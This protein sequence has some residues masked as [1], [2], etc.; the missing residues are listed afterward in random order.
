MSFVSAVA[1]YNCIIIATDG[2]AKKNGQIVDEDAVKV[3]V[4][5]PDLVIAYTGMKEV[6]EEVITINKEFIN[7][8]K[9]ITAIGNTLYKKIN[10]SRYSEDKA[11]LIIAGKNTQGKY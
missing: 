5:N 4:L 6:C 3:Q 10:D 7:S 1:R 11:S 9:N 8:T 2:R